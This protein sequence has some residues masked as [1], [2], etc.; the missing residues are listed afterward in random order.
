MLS[1]AVKHGFTRA[2]IPK[3]N[4]P[5]KPIDGLDIIAVERLSEALGEMN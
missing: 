4:R 3:S 5:R 2:I 1:E